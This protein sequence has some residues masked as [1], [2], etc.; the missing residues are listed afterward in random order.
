ME[1]LSAVPT[2]K[3]SSE[4]VGL[5]FRSTALYNNSSTS[6][7]GSNSTPSS[8]SDTSPKDIDLRQLPFKPIPVHDAANEIDASITSHPPMEWKLKPLP[9]IPKVNYAV[10][11]ETARVRFSKMINPNMY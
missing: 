3:M 8:S 1:R 2:R 10:M 9:L 11:V 4:D 6:L 7:Y 5:I